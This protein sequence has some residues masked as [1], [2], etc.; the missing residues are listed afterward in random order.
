MHYRIK[1]FAEKHTALFL[2]ISG[3]CPKNP[4]SRNSCM[5]AGTGRNNLLAVR[6]RSSIKKKEIRNFSE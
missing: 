1:M 4:D 6:R 5:T 2:I 3:E